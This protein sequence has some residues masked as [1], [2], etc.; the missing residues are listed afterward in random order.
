MATPLTLVNFNTTNGSN[1]GDGVVMDAAG[2]LFGTTNSGGANGDGTVYEIVNTGTGYATAPVTLYSFTATNGVVPFGHLLIDAAGDLFGTT[3][4]DGTTSA[5]TVYEIVKTPGGYA[6]TPTILANFDNTHGA[7]PTGTLIEDAKGDL[8]GTT[9]GGG[10]LGDGVVFEIVN[11]P[12]GYASTPAVVTDFNY[13]TVGG[14]N[15]GLV[16]DAA[17]DLFGTTK[18]GGANSGGTVFEI[19]NT[20]TGLAST[21][22]VLSA[23]T[24]AEGAHPAN[25]L[26][27]DSAGDLF[28]TTLSNTVFEIRNT[29]SGYANTPTILTTFVGSG[30]DPYGTLLLD[31]AGNLWG[32]TLNGGGNNLGMIY[33]LVRSGSS[34]SS[35]P[36]VV[37]NFNSGG[38]Y[39]PYAGLFANASGT[40]FGTTFAG[41]TGSSGTVFELT[42]S[43]FVSCFRA[44]TRVA[45]ENGPVPVEALVEG[46]RVLT[47]DGGAAPVRW[48][49]HR[50]ID[51]RRHP[52][53]EAVWPIRVRAG[54]FEPGI[55]ERD[56]WLSPDHAV[57]ADGVLIPIRHLVNGTNIVRHPV[58]EVD[59][60][61]VELPE[62]DVLFAEGLPVES[63]LETGSRASFDNGGPVVRLHPDF[64]GRA[65][66]GLGCAPLVLSGPTL[67]GVRRRV[68]ARAVAH[69][70][71]TG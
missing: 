28:G 15:P 52:R 44:G 71:A 11:T 43:G 24:S 13:S 51:I 8:F 34:Y 27:I 30:V 46:D 32:T 64:N 22:T 65:W 49:G 2:D 67:D 66:D 69:R 58:A 35:T 14:L 4:N 37:W 38:N 40:L 68:N 63:Y 18:N 60:Y 57:F 70:P 54:A 42:G 55:P 36:N 5:G 21:P 45:T 33:E 7:N 19:V 20:A 59:Y 48:M 10:S 56:L 25:G 61:H 17:G 53:P 9:Q 26:A 29:A 41:G 16:L 1:P 31:N 12:T 39:R 50:H 23:F 47:R 6:T 3:P 62:H